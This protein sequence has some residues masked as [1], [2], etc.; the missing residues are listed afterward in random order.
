VL[1]TEGTITLGG[2]APRLDLAGDWSKFRW[3]LGGAAFVESTKGVYTF[4]GA[5]PYEFTVKADARGPNIPAADFTAS[6]SIDRDRLVLKRMDG[7]TLKGQLRGSGSV[8]WRGEAPWRAQVD[9]RALDLAG[10]RPDLVGRIDVSGDIAGRG[11]TPDAPWTARLAKLSGTLYGRALTGSGEVSH[12][13]GAYEFRGV[14]L[15]NAGSHVDIDGRWG[16]QVDLRWSADL[17]SLGLI[18]PGLRGS[19]VST[20]SARGTAARPQIEASAR[21]GGFGYGRI[22]AGAIDAD[23][24]VDLG[25]GRDSRVDVHATDVVFA[26]QQYTTA[27]L[28]VDGRTSDHD[29]QIT[30][31]SR[32]NPERKFAGFEARIEAA[33]SADVGRRAWQGTLLEAAFE[34]PDGGAR[35]VQ[36]AALVLA[37]DRIDVAPLCLATGD[38]RLCVE[39][40]WR[41]APESWRVLYS[42]QDWPLRRLITTLLGRR[43]FDGKLQ[44]SGWAEQQP[45]QDWIGGAALIVDDPTFEV[46]RNQSR[47]DIV[48]IGGGRI[49]LFADAGELRAMADMDMAA[50]TRL[51]GEVRAP[52]ERG[53]PLAESPLSGEVRAESAVLTA[54]PLF[55]PEIDRSEGR[56]DGAVRVGGTLGDPR[57]DGEFHLR[58]GRLDL[59]RTNLSLTGATLDG[60]FVGDTLEFSG[61]ATSRKGPLTLD[62]RFSWPEGVMTGSM[63]LKG[64][65]LLVAD[66]PE[67]RILASPDLTIRAEG[68]MY[69]VTG[70]VFIPSA[71]IA[72]KDLSTSVGTSEDE[73]IVGGEAE[74]M[75]PSTMQRVRS[76]IRVRLGDDVRVD[77]YGLKA[78]L[79]GEVVVR[80]EPGDRARGE[81]AINVIQG[82]YKAFGVF[83]KITRGVLS[84]RDS[85]LGEPVLDLVAEREIKDEDVRVVVNVRGELDNPFVTLS[86]EPAMPNNEALSYLLT[87]RSLNTLQSNEAANVNRA[88]ES[89]AISG[90]GLLLGGLGTRLGLDEV[91]VESAGADDTQ[92][93]L[94]KFLSPK[95]FVSYGISIAEAINTVKLR[96]TLNPRWS[97]K[98]EAGLEQS[99]DVEFRIER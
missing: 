58:D 98:A 37:P 57:F 27:R 79:G 32:G 74:E 49:D 92:V 76:E 20:G 88:A 67:F 31:V 50:S 54:L 66:T 81:G 18:D 13:K 96:Y 40:E 19:L 51:R 42:A 68:G 63:R 6:G 14:R 45:G 9:G 52:R 15:A 77:S 91:S 70:E 48:R 93:V 12:A 64:E 60:R 69:T 75:E 85:P 55:V 39:A 33:G 73:R 35:L 71:M 8:S 61:E 16:A 43:D 23:L 41:S 36:P 59:Y 97:L 28:K 86:S 38:A 62:G 95:L 84:F 29:L 94:G 72:P 25:D 22:E 24:D 56:L 65:S 80:T 87:G 5:M 17:R 53:R 34:F 44:L 26:G 2:E 46:R 82:E 78:T 89:L 99:A 83:V 3:P 47:K 1:T 30:A 4:A 21:L 90:G 11:F 7:T 10:L